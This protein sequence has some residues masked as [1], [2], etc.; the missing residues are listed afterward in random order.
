MV[1]KK[2]RKYAKVEKESIVAIVRRIFCTCKA[3]KSTDIF[4]SKQID[5]T[6]FG[7]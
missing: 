7:R 6:L 2:L 1:R 4:H 3:T 5:I